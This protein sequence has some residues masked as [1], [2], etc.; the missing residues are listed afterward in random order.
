MAKAKKKAKRSKAQ[1]KKK[2]ENLVKQL[3]FQDWQKRFKNQ[4]KNGLTQF[5]ELI[6]WI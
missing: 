6:K 2:V 4:M 5:Q 3:R 1:K